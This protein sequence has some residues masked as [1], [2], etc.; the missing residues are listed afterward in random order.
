MTDG[1]DEEDER[2][3][4]PEGVIKKYPYK[5]IINGEE[6]NITGALSY[7]FLT[8][9]I[10]ANDERSEIKDGD[11]II[12]VDV[13]ARIRILNTDT[14]KFIIELK[15]DIFYKIPIFFIV[16][17]LRTLA[18]TYYKVVTIIKRLG[19]DDP[20]M[21]IKKTELELLEFTNSERVDL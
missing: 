7:K 8:Q 13:S 16:D 20:A 18:N 17:E 2:K 11:E 4:T 10:I 12:E 15:D 3:A 21:E 1:Y 6:Y 14:G 5:E 19:Y 9:T